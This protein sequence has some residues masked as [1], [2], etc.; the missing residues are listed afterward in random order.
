MAPRAT[1]FASHDNRTAVMLTRFG[2]TPG[3]TS[4][5]STYRQD[6][7]SASGRSASR[8]NR[9]PRHGFRTSVD[10]PLIGAVGPERATGFGASSVA[11]L[12]SRRRFR[13]SVRREV[14]HHPDR[15]F[16]SPRDVSHEPTVPRFGAES[17]SDSSVRCADVRPWR[18]TQSRRC[19]SLWR[20][21]VIDKVDPVGRFWWL[22]AV[23]ARW[24]ASPRIRP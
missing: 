24:G 11:A 3:P 12:A 19:G 17:P 16:A 7:I 10:R 21:P 18:V 22:P 23:G 1:G 6:R 9:P 20:R 5:R 8:S 14:K 13:R 2:R 4:R 15:G